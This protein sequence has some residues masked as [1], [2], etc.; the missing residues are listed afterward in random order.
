MNY[1][2][3]VIRCDRK[4][5]GIT[6]SQ[7]NKIT[8]RC[9]RH[10]KQSVIE[11]FISAKSDWIKKV[12]ERNNTKFSDNFDVIN[13]KQ[14]YIN[15]LKVPLIIGSENRVTNNAVYVKSL[16][17]L[18]GLI[19]KHFSSELLNSA[20]TLA[21]RTKLKARSFCVKAYK[22]KWGCCDKKGVITLNCYLAMLPPRIRTY[23]IIHELCHTV[24]F[25]HSAAF[26]KLVEKF[27]PNYAEYQKYLKSVNFITR[28][29]VPKDLK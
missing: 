22:A 28:I 9:P 5:I 15:G 11:N 16:G 18:Q 6:I 1:D 3:T 21:E 19:I 14:T 26:W 13:Y 27:E 20:K 4:S 29:Y 17:E 23:V 24:H 2:Y 8:V 25:N 10:V 7:D 12:I